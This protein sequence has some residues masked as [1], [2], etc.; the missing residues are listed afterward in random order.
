[1]QEAEQIDAPNDVSGVKKFEKYVWLAISPKA[2]SKPIFL[3]S[4]TAVEKE[5]YCQKCIQKILI[6][7][8][9]KLHLDGN[10]LFWLPAIML[11]LLQTPLKTLI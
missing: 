4:G 9:N 7:F 3:K 6:P 10:Y 11:I 1:M 2:I 8:I 5:I